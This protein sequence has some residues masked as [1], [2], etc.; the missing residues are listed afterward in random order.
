MDY[1]KLVGTGTGTPYPAATDTAKEGGQTVFGGFELIDDPTNPH[2]IGHGVGHRDPK[3]G[4]PISA[5]VHIPSRGE[6]NP[7]E[8]TMGAA[9]EAQ[10]ETYGELLESKYGIQTPGKYHANWF[11]TKSMMHGVLAKITK[12]E[13]HMEKAISHRELADL[14]LN[15]FNDVNGGYS[16]SK[17]S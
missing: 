9:V 2:Y 16:F 3:S 17:I 11:K 13:K 4:Q 15:A 8:F 5:L 7:K 12:S 14:E 10:V 6:T 1:N